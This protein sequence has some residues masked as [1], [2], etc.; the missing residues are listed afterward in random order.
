MVNEQLVDYIKNEKSQ[1]YSSQQLYD[2]LIQQG[3]NPNDIKEAIDYVEKPQT[4]SSPNKK[5]T[6]IG[7]S[8][9]IFIVVVVVSFWFLTNPICNN[10]LECGD[11]DIN[12]L[13]VCINPSER[14]SKCLNAQQTQLSDV[15]EEIT[16]NQQDSVSFKINDENHLI[17]VEEV[18]DNSVRLAIYSEPKK[19][20]LSIGESKEID[21][22]ND[23]LNDLYVKLVR[24]TD[25]KPVFEI[26]SLEKSGKLN[27]D[28]TSSKN[29]YQMAEAVSG[30]FKIDYSGKPFNGIVLYSYSKDG[31]DE[32]YYAM[33]R[34]SISSS[35][36]NVMKV[37]FKAFRLDEH[38]YSAGTDYFYNEGNYHYTI[39][40]YGCETVTSTLNK[41]CFKI[42]EEEL[43]NVNP[44]KTISKTIKVQG[45]VNPSECRVSEDCT[46]ICA[47]C[48]DGTQICEQSD[49]KCMDCFMDTQCKSG[50]KCRYNTCV[51][52]ECD[53]NIDCNDN[54]A[55]TKDICTDFKCSNTEITE[56]VDNDLY[57]P[58][59]CD[60][61]TDND[62]TDKCGGQVTD[63]ETSVLSQETIGN[64]PNHDCFID[65]AKDC[66]P[67][68]LV[69]ETE[70]NFFGMFVY[71]KTYREINGLENESCVLY[72]RT[73][74]TSYRYSEETR[75]Q[76]L[77]SGM[78]EEQIDEQLAQ[79]NQQ[80]QEMIIGKD[81]TC[82]Y[83][84]DDL[85]NILEEEKQGRFSGSTEDVEKYQCT[86]S[87]YE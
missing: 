79:Q 83:P 11:D 68:K 13:D 39:S 25:G 42:V 71:S 31:F 74:N 43:T 15:E 16:I 10:D 9:I 22:D 81:S 40:V 12:T 70:I 45:G 48:K 67:A 72:Q 55:S 52:W 78:T 61:D 75:Q 54:D 38:G 19:V 50:Y 17:E 49:E 76:M 85:V 35:N 60:T 2:Y 20:T 63:C 41:D 29:T 23:G 8:A 69:T 3:Y 51:A 6:F 28:I 56:C 82:R 87:M 58:E 27:L 66:C 73:D 62:C 65:K 57:C 84:I 36:M 30:E 24:I 64:V 77:D 14:I 26:K 5:F 34:G 18:T 37:A 46:K 21:T 47:G 53:E 33:T 7:V 80:A 4:S 44:L 59:G 1:G 86:G 32:K